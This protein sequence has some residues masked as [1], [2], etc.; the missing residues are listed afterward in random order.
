[1]E[2]KLEH[3]TSSGLRALIAEL[4]PPEVCDLVEREHQVLAARQ[5]LQSLS[6]QLRHAETEAR[7][8]HRQLCNW[9]LSHPLRTRLHYWGW[10]PSRFLGECESGKSVLETEVLQ[11]TEHVHF[12]AEH[13]KEIEREVEARIQLEQAPVRKRIAELECLWQERAAQEQTERQQTQEP[14][15]DLSPF[16]M[17]KLRRERKTRNLRLAEADRTSAGPSHNTGTATER[18][19]LWKVASRIG[20]G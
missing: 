6:E 17:H 2:Q 9:R 12:A 8:A 1:M 19:G 11:L 18:G 13:V 4:R 14:G 7:A 3:L 15:S 5:M 20:R 10:M 16:M